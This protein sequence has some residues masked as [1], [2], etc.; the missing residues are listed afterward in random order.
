[1]R[2]ILE[3]VIA[4]IGQI[5]V[6]EHYDLSLRSMG[7][8]ALMQAIH[9]SRD[10]KPD[11]LYIGNMLAS[12][13]SHQA[14]L[15]ALFTD[16]A[17]LNGVESYTMEAAGASGAAA[18]RLGV[19][20][21]LSGYADT[22]AVLGV[23]KWS[24]LLREEAEARL[25][26]EM[27]FDFEAIPGLTSSGLAGLIQQR[28]LHEHDLSPDALSGFA[29]LAHANATSNPNAFHRQ[30]LSM[31]AYN[32]G[33]QTS[34]P[35]NRFDGGSY[36]DGA[37]AV[38]LTRLDRLPAD[39]PHAIIRIAGTG[40]SSDSLSWHDRYEPLSF[41]AAANAVFAATQQAE[42]K[43]EQISLFE[44]DDAFSIYAALTL[45]TCGMADVGRSWQQARDG[46]FA[47]SGRL[48]LMTMGGSLAR[49]NAI[50]AVGVYQI[51]EAVTQLRGQ[52]GANQVPDARRA[53]TLSLGGAASTAIA[54]VLERVSD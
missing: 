13:I 38:I 34:D 19:L 7:V 9:D 5:P 4:G 33:A 10:L 48:P 31:E 32:R 20:S 40:A 35:L 51:V 53:L 37:A 12:M 23:E 45:E 39:Y 24:D 3:V 22:V 21:I 8:R 47:L 27:D 26:Q 2:A 42:V 11:A 14:N 54:H 6:G 49:G 44:L 46:D 1:M 30:P 41:S 18:L 50:G 43:P 29:L 16:Y 28:Y 36:A 25:T 52:A 15:G 17:H